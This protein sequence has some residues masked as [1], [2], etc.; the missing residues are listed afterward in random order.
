LG[1]ATLADTFARPGAHETLLALQAKTGLGFVFT[2]RLGL[3]ARM[4]PGHASS[5]KIDPERRLNPM[6]APKPRH[7]VCAEIL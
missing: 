7:A 5:Y 2:F 3:A 4:F 6:M 1:F